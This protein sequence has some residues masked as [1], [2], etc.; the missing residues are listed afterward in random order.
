MAKKAAETADSGQTANGASVAG[1]F[2]PIFLKNPKLLKERSNEALY[3]Q[4]LK[5]HPGTTAVPENVKQGLSNLKSVLR[6]K[7]GAKRGPK[8]KDQQPAQAVAQEAAPR[9]P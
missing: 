2:R 7:L 8:P 5:D 9:R 4:W 3:Q 6:K 1:Y